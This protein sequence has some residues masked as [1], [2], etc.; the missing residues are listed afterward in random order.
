MR[1]AFRLSCA[2]VLAGLIATEPA[3]QE[4]ERE[5]PSQLAEDVAGPPDDPPLGLGGRCRIEGERVDQGETR[6]LTSATGRRYLALCGMGLNN[7]SWL[8]QAETCPD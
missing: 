2:M 8:P 3:A 1:I 4:R 6:C 7:T 5:W